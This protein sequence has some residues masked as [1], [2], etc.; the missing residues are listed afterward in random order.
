MAKSNQPCRQQC[1]GT[2]NIYVSAPSVRLVVVFVSNFLFNFVNPPETLRMDLVKTQCSMTEQYCIKRIVDVVLPDAL[3]DA[4]L[5]P[6][7]SCMRLS[8]YWSMS[9]REERCWRDFVIQFQT[10]V[11]FFPFSSTCI[12]HHQLS[13]TSLPHASATINFHPHIFPMHPPPS[14]FT[15]MSSPC[16]HHHHLPPT[17]LPHAATTITFHPHIFP[18]H[19][20]PSPFTHISSPC[21]HHHHLPPTYLPHASTTITFHP[22]VFHMHP[23]P[24]PSTHISSPCIHHHQLSPTYLPYASTTTTFTHISSPCIHHHQLSPTYL[25]HAS[26]TINF[27][28][29][30]FP[31]HPPPSTFTHIS[32]PCIHHHHLSPTSLPHASTTINF[33]THI[34]PMHPPPSTFT[35]ISSPCIHHHQLPPTSLL[36]ALPCRITLASSLSE[37]WAGRG[38]S[39]STISLSLYVFRSLSTLVFLAP[40]TSALRMFIILCRFCILSLHYQISRG[41]NY[42]T[43][44]PSFRGYQAMIMEYVTMNGC[45]LRNDVY[46][47]IIKC[48]I[49]TIQLQCKIYLYIVYTT[50]SAGY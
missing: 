20:P 8:S 6:V 17:Y 37:G 46:S 27:H 44:L 43:L 1:L 40:P 47:F 16:I 22:H 35:H 11:N 18:M 7:L 5:L 9:C 29:H 12:H 32:S 13:P 4:T 25:P 23:P 36:I 30:P 41:S 15:H 10:C 21:I 31:M 45:S 49:N 19:P 50:L 39:N 2:N 26:T 24:P 28:P 48:K 42:C 33:H 34:F 14:P 38:G 3:G